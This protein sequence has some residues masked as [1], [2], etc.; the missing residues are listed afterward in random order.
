MNETNQ[1]PALFEDRGEI[2]TASSDAAAVARATQEVQAAL[3]IAQRFPRDEVKAR[4]RILQACQRKGLAEV[5]EYEYSRGGSKITGPSIDL[6]RA[7]ASRWGHLRWGWAEVERRPAGVEPYGQSMVRTYCWDM[8]SGAYAERTF[9]VSHWRD[10]QS[11]GY[12]LDDDRDIYELLANM[13]AR[14]VRAC[15]EEVIDSD[16]VTDAVDQCRVTLRSGEKEPM[17][18]RATKMV[19][20]YVEFGVT[21]EMIEQRIQQ[22]LESMSEIQYASLRRIYKSL[23]DGIGKAEDFFKPIAAKPEFSKAQQPGSPAPAPSTPPAPPAPPADAPPADDQV[24]GAEVPPPA[25]AQG[26]FNPLKAVRNLCKMAR[27]KEGVLVGYLAEIGATDG[28]CATL[29]EV[30]MTKPELL[31][32]V[33]EQWSMH[34]EKLK[35][36]GVAK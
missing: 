27:V 8:Q 2:L 13:A 32:L 21:Q 25:E 19:L 36:A 30:Q 28:S 31:R 9:S 20:A 4:A 12:A 3:V 35:A 7:I 29:E 16:I 17:K 22:K 6:L 24:P 23:K 10:T 26:G 5:S 11:G 1:V 18:A 15:M 34:L 33:S 14:R